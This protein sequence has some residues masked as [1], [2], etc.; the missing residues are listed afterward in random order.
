MFENNLPFITLDSKF[1]IIDCNQGIKEK[2]AGLLMPDFFRNLLTGYDMDYFSQPVEFNASLLNMSNIN[3][4]FFKDGDVLKCLPVKSETYGTDNAWNVHY[5]MREPISSIF[6]MLPLLADNINKGDS[7]KAFSN[8]DILNQQS[9]KLLKSVNNV[10]LASRIMSGNLPEKEYV[11]FSALL[12]SLIDSV[13]AVEKNVDIK[14]DIDVGIY[15]HI[16]KS[17]ITNAVLNLISNSINFRTDENVQITIWLTKNDKNVVFSYSDNS[18]GIK[19]E[20]LPYVFTPYYSKDPFADGE[21]DPSMGLGLF[22]VKNAFEYAGGKILR[23]SSFGQG[24]KYNI[25]LPFCQPVGN[26]LESRS[27]DF[28]LNR[29]SE[30]FV[31]LCDS[32]RLPSLK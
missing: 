3:L 12:E 1:N 18:K 21:P 25:S 30:L 19:D 17:F 27:T 7:A 20:L 14:A 28:L 13:K 11:D 32:C 8:L 15:L 31:Q 6:A 29:Y 4:V 10:S 23:T 24:V 16:N 5:Q 26:V 9:Y 2:Y 22:I